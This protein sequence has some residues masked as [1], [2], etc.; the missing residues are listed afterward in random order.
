VTASCRL[1]AAA[2]ALLWLG[3]AG[4]ADLPPGPAANAGGVARTAP[5]DSDPWNLVPDTV[6]SLADLDLAALRASPWS[7][8]LV[9][10]GFV[11]DREAR[12]REFGYDVFNDADRV[13]IA[14]IDVA[15][16]ERQVV[17]VFGRLD[18]ARAGRAFR[19][20]GPGAT[21]A[22]WRDCHIWERGDRALAAVGRALVQGTPET[23]R[24][25]IDAAWGVVPDAGASPLGTLVRDLGVTGARR[26]ALKV[27]VTITDDVRARAEGVVEVPPSLRRGAVR[28]DLGADLE[29]E[30]L[31]ILD[32]PAVANEAARA[33]G[34][35]LRELGQN[36]ML[37]IMGLSPLVEGASL[38]AEG[39]RVHGRLRVPESKREGLSE[40][41][42]ILLQAIAKQRGP[43]PPP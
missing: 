10:G 40:R 23:V 17:V 13:V 20:A 22:S 25:A 21:E 37:R 3:A 18:I 12:L 30:A 8:A 43:Q 2:A 19:E 34:M 9:T 26:P 16:Q 1:R 41:A 28:L 5:D 32:S 35:A 24:A 7:R 31:A 42:M 14:A 11:E 36:R 15:G 29:L 39:A 38:S 4:C 6:A 27:G 33:W